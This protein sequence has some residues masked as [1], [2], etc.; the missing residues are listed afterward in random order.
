MVQTE[1]YFLFPVEMQK[2]KCYDQV[3][4]VRS[5]RLGSAELADVLLVGLL[6]V[7]LLQNLLLL[8]LCS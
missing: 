3:H 5:K 7:V 2:I 4:V 6:L 1:K 8:S